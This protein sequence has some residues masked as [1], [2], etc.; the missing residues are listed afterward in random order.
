MEAVHKGVGVEGELPP[1]GGIWLCS[2]TIPDACPVTW[3]ST[4]DG[5]HKAGGTQVATPTRALHLL[6]V[7]R[8][9][10]PSTALAPA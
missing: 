8:Y 7:G 9:A 2:L 6:I 3:R 10:V 1:S 5:K 4:T